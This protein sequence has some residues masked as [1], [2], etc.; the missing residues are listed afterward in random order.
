[1]CGAG[2]GGAG[3]AASAAADALQPG[4]RGTHRKGGVVRLAC[5]M[6]PENHV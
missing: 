3:G 4:Q 5:F 2:G 1:M 6:S